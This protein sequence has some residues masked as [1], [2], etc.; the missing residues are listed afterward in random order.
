MNR[1]KKYKGGTR[2]NFAP[3]LIGQNYICEYK[4]QK[5]GLDCSWMHLNISNKKVK[6]LGEFAY[7]WYTRQMIVFDFQNAENSTGVYNV[8]SKVQKIVSANLVEQSIIQSD[9]G[10][11]NTSFIVKRLFDKSNNLT[12][13]MSDVGFKHNSLIESL[14]G[15]HKDIFFKDYGDSF[16]TLKW[17]EKG[18]LSLPVVLLLVFLMKGKNEKNKIQ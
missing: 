6:I 16:K 12:L 1:P 3:D 2:G 17:R 11:A 8:L 15:W 9:R 14:N 18:N 4:Y 10:T 13:S 7:D 5:I